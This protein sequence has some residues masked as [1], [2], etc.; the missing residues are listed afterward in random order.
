MP[1]FDVM[2]FKF[3]NV[4][5]TYVH[6]CRLRLGI[7]T[8]NHHG[9]ASTHSRQL[10]SFALLHTVDLYRYH[11]AA[12]WTSMETRHCSTSTLYIQLAWVFTAMFPWNLGS[13]PNN[14]AEFPPAYANVTIQYIICQYHESLSHVPLQDWHH[15]NTSIN[16]LEERFSSSYVLLTLSHNYTSVIPNHHGSSSEN[17]DIRLHY[18]SLAKHPKSSSLQS[19]S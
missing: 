4:Y 15:E 14:S 8:I 16:H 13:A 1:L 3:F 9:S 7:D 2:C 19:N 5:R 12:M 18:S 10:T 6:S 11:Q 17:T